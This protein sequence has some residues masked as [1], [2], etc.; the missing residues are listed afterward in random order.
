MKIRVTIMWLAAIL[1]IFSFVNVS[2]SQGHKEWI[3]FLSPTKS[4]TISL[5]ELP[6]QETKIAKRGQRK[7]TDAELSIFKCSKSINYYRLP[8]L[9]N[10]G[11]FR[12]IIREIDITGCKRKSSDFETELMK[13]LTFIVG[14]TPAIGLEQTFEE[15]KLQYRKISYESGLF[16]EGTSDSKIQN[17]LMAI[18]AGKKIF[19]LIY[20][21]AEGHDDYSEIFRT[22]VTK[23]E[24]N[25]LI[26]DDRPR[27]QPIPINKEK[28]I[29]F[30]P[31]DKSFTIEF[32]EFPK[33][34]TKVATL[35][36]ENETDINLYALRCTKSVSMFSLPSLSESNHSRISVSVTDVSR[37]HRKKNEFYDEINGL[38]S[39]IGGDSRKALSDKPV[40][41]NGLRGREIIY[42][43]GSEIYGRTLAV[44]AGNKIIFLTYNRINGDLSEEERVFRTFKPKI[45]K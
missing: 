38:F 26:I 4:F 2:F 22:F 30:S 39:F 33:E 40:K 13:F 6:I 37:C 21:G 31:I 15:N 44:D 7:D 10:E 17:R 16:Y 18:N 23:F 1:M 43:N 3:S 41:I 36:P 45:L 8:S 27:I 9:L 24:K 28:W 5:P 32:P 25:P 12:L 34:E 11:K 35:D 14:K 20:N 42:K 29:T 19:I